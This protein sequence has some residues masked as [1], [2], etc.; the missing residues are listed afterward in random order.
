[1]KL[2]RKISIISALALL[3]LG[4]GIGVFSLISLSPPS[5]PFE[6]SFVTYTNSSSQHRLAL[7]SIRNFARRPI[8]VFPVLPQVQQ[9]GQWPQNLSRPPSYPYSHVKAGQRVYFTVTAPDD[10][11]VWRLP[12]LWDFSPNIL[13][14]ARAVLRENWLAFQS[15]SPWRGLS[16]GVGLLRTNFTAEIH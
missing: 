11:E 9:R 3:P 2:S 4:L 1:M 13:D 10:G 8:N 7:F 6:L 16:V 14:F 12:T 5:P 15:G